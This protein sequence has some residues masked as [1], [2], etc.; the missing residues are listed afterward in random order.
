M[1]WAGVALST[2]YAAIRISSF[3]FGTA[4]RAASGGRRTDDRRRRPLFHV[5]G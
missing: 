1:G 4:S 3:F 5:A 2:I